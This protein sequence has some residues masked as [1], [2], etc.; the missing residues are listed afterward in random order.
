LEDHEDT[1][2]HYQGVCLKDELETVYRNIVE[3]KTPD[4]VEQ[5]PETTLMEYCKKY[6]I[7]PDMT[8]EDCLKAI[9]AVHHGEALRA[10][11]KI[12]S[13]RKSGSKVHVLWLWGQV[14]TGKSFFSRKISQI[15]SS[16]EV[17]WRGEYLPSMSSTMP[18]ISTQLVTC[19]E[20]DFHTAFGPATIN[21]TKQL[22]EGRGGLTRIG[23]YKQYS[24]R[25][26]DASFLIAS[27]TIPHDEAMSKDGD[28]QANIWEPILK[29]AK[30]LQMTHVMPESKT[31][32]YTVNQMAHAL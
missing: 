13:F 30:L 10:I 27:N 24:K 7:D 18:H 14:S 29:R 23:P 28:F 4:P 17:Q 32:A 31:E 16:M 26:G 2:Y 6:P 12:L 3:L 5:A 19:E 22:F 9:D 15:F 11:H 20:F 8:P 1:E 21:T 25:F